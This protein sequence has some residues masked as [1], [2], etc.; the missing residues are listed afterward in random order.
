MTSDQIARLK[1]SHDEIASQPRALAAR[2]YEELFAA[3]PPLRQLFPTDMT[4]LMGH[5]E[6]ALAL[7]IRNL[8]DMGA[9][10]GPLSELGVQHVHWGARPEHYA[11]VRD[12]LISAI[13]A[14]SSTWSDELEADWR[15]AIT[16]ICVPMLQGAAVHHA[17]VAERMADEG[18]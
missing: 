16:A 7:V 4:S 1:R 11:I 12:A 15:S 13:R 8:G 18:V 10:V 3:A 2:F 5:F 9:L 6:A 14:S 17:V